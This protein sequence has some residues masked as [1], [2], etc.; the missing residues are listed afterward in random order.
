VVS[1]LRDRADLAIDLSSRC[2]ADPKHLPSGGFTAESSGLRVFVT[3]VAR[4]LRAPRDAGPSFDLRLFPRPKT[5]AALPVGA[6]ASMRRARRS[7]PA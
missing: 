7:V 2:A 5:R 6:P 3:S 4:R 1:A